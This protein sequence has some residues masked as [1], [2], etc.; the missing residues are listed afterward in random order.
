MRIV[1]VP[2]SALSHKIPI[3]TFAS[4]QN[5]NYYGKGNDLFRCVR[6][7]PAI[8]RRKTIRSDHDSVVC[9]SKDDVKGYGAYGERTYE[10][11]S[12]LSD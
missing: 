1:N 11:S 4:N 7:V 12:Q 5:K 9:K 8:Q 6:N 10:E 2:D 3:H